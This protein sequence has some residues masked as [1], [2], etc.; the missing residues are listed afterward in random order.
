MRVCK[1]AEGEKRDIEELIIEAKGF[2]ETYKK[3]IGKS[4][5]EDKK[6]VQIDFNDLAEY[7]H[8]LSETLLISPEEI[9]Q[10][11]ETA[12]DDIGLIKNPRVRL[13]N[14]P[15]TLDLRIGHI[16]ARHLNSLISITGIVRQASEVR[17][18]VVNAKFECPSCG[19]IISVLQVEKKFREPARCSCGRKGQFRLLT[20]EMVDAQR[21]VIEESPES[22]MGG[23]QPR[24]LS[25]FLQEDLV[26]PRMEEKTTPG[27]RINIIGVLKEI[28][29]PLQTGSISTR[30][31]LALEANN[32]IPLEETFE[33]VKIDEEDER[34]IQELAADPKLFENL[35]DSIA[36]A[37]WGYEEIKKSLVLQ[38]F[39]GVRK[40]SRDGSVKR[41]DIHL[42]L[43]GD[44]GVAKSFTL[45]F[46]SDMAPKGRYIVGKAASGAGIT[47]TVVRDEF[48]KGWSLEA[49]A[50][51]LAHKGIVCI[52]E[53][54]KMDPNDRSAMHE[55]MEQQ[56][57][58][59]SKANVQATL[60]AQT[61]VLAAGNPKLGR[62]EPFQSIAQQI[63][64]PPA[65]IN[66]FDIIFTL[67]DL[68][69]KLKDESI[70]THVLQ[71][72]QKD[73]T[74]PPV[75]RD[76]FKKYVAYAKQ[77][78]HP[79]L[80]DEAVNEI[81]NFYVRLR[82]AP[83]SSNSLVRPIPISARQLEALVRISEAHAKMR[84]SKT[85][86][87]DD[88]KIAIA[89][90]KYYLMQVGYDEESKQFDIDKIAV[91]VSTSQ[92]SKVIQLRETITKLEEKLGKF[93]PVEE[94]KKEL[95]NKMSET[96]IDDALQKL[97]S[98]GDVFKPRRGFIQKI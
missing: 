23:E 64:L 67:R 94:L 71:T 22:L 16:R 62:F 97:I 8:G 39:S 88:A 77:K 26:E 10:V 86:T 49:G 50:M 74:I 90:M 57:V 36:P 79:A 43:I 53:I 59:I 82:N 80:T 7:S 20:K 48:L 9:F 18:Q 96:E 52:D 54:E 84:L 45:K 76:L 73:N 4:I 91:G 89:L 61:S 17:P 15:K 38:M 55:A 30:F 31:D 1:M 83:V 69:D 92:R 46:I 34:Q 81:K 87:K 56:T 33:D 2:F 6:V 44:P 11:L 5:R 12:L 68:P 14:V 35:A 51:V 41:G 70:A 32:I 29:I 60:H 66:R 40:V 78:C 95:E 65:L 27:S 21:L 75:E 24:R 47:A 72:H 13:L 3:E 98:S 63:D 37:I 42:F 58:T 93:I 85:V 28:P 25:V 19:T